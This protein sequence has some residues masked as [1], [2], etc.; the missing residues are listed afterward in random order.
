MQR[1]TTN[2]IFIGV[3]GLLLSLGSCG[4]ANLREYV[5]YVENTEHGLHLIQQSNDF[6]LEAQYKP[7]EYVLLKERHLKPDDPTW[8]EELKE[9][10][11]YEYYTLHIKNIQGQNLLDVA[12]TD[13][14]STS[15]E[16]YFS[17][18]L[19][20]DFYLLT[21]SD[22]LSSVLFHWPRTYELSVQES[23]MLVFPKGDKEADRRLVYN[24]KV[25]GMGRQEFTVEATDIQSVPKLN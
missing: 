3:W 6:H 17:F 5:N 24:D 10:Q 20:N 23:F 13:E 11:G 2:I 21:G 16:H 1:L 18:E 22:S 14:L 7:A 4:S 15:I 25:L 19:E 9:L 12:K 8:D